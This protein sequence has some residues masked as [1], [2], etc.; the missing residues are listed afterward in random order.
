[1]FSEQVKRTVKKASERR[2]YSE[3]KV[4]RSPAGYFVG[5]SFTT[6]EGYEEPGS[7][8]SIYF[9]SIQE[10][11]RTLKRLESGE[12]DYTSPIMRLNP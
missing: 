2:K 8:D 12:I 4:C 1:M 5:T 7:R 11:E 9:Q 10:A 3:L 6:D